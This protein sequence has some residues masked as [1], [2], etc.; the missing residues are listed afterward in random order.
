M[1]EEFKSKSNRSTASA[2]TPLVPRY[3]GEGKFMGSGQK[4]GEMS[5][6]SGGLDEMDKKEELRIK[7]AQDYPK[8]LKQSPDIIIRK[9]NE[10]YQRDVFEEARKRF[11]KELLDQKK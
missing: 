1:K 11:E 2:M 5:V 7:F 9:P 6:L 3:D 4:R 8:F 10:Q